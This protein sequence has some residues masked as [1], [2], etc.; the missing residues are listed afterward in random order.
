ML[1]Y[2]TRSLGM[3][4]YHSAAPRGISTCL[5]TL[6]NILT[7]RSLHCRYTTR[8]RLVEYPHMPRT[9]C[10]DVRLG[11]L[12]YPSAAPRGISACLTVHQPYTP[13]INK[14]PMVYHINSRLLKLSP[15][16]IRWA[17]LTASKKRAGFY[18]ATL[19]NQNFSRSKS[20]RRDGSDDRGYLHQH[21]EPPAW[22]WLPDC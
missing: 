21:L 8:L 10:S 20:K 3:Y 1:K 5:V 11:M 6:L 2:S 13:S 12:I 15:K 16:N 4:I 9:V 14:P 22:T 7:N 17:H 19:I 18:Q